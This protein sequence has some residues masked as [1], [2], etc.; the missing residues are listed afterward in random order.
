[1][2]TPLEASDIPNLVPILFE[3]VVSRDTGESFLEEI[4]QIQGY[5]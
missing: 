2:V 1:M 3:S 4:E 5:M